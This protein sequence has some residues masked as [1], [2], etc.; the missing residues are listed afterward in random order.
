M[1]DKKILINA[2][3]IDFYRNIDISEICKL[4]WN[5]KIIYVN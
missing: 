1:D 5:G 3:N 2:E 4:F